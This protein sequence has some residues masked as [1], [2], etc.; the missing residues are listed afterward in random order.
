[1]IQKFWKSKTI[2]RTI[3]AVIL[4]T[5]TTP[6]IAQE[7]G[8]I[9]ISE[10]KGNVKLKQPNWKSYQTVY[11]GELLNTSDKLR[12]VKGESVKVI[13][14]NLQVWNLNSQGEFEVAKGCRSSTRAVLTRPDSKT[15]PTRAG[16]DPTIPYLISPR[17]SAILTRQPILRWHPLPGA[18]SYQVKVSGPD[19]EWTTKVSQPEVV[20]SGNQPLKPGLRYRVIVIASNGAST[21]GKDNAGFTLLSNADTQRVKTEM[22]KLQQQ[23]L[24][25]ESKTLVLAHLYRSNN[26]NADAIE[27]L[28]GLVKQRNKRTA[29]YQLLG[30]IYQQIGLT[31]L[32]RERYITALQLAKAEN[33]LAAQAVSQVNLGEVDITLAHSKQAFQWFQNAQSSYRTLGDEAK[34]REMQH[35]LDY[36]KGR[37]Y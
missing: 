23:P 21:E 17:N 31:E 24:S 37:I 33:N 26:L 14:D 1:M 32:A 9:F 36:L 12:L 25:N 7:A 30:S 27:L 34:V 16:N 10:V 20:Y 11:G 6:S 18:T 15:S 5:L 8:L 22:A 28:E 35:Q 13:C 19:V 4:T 2:S 3:I 29:V